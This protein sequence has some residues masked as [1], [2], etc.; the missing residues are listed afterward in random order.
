MARAAPPDPASVLT[1]AI[2]KRFP[3]SYTLAS[4]YLK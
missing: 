1:I 2:R 3:H 4:P